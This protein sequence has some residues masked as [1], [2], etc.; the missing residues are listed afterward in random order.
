MNRWRPFHG[1]FFLV[2]FCGVLAVTPLPA[3]TEVDF[4]PNIEFSKYKTFV[5][6]G[7]VENL[8]ML[9]LDPDVMNDR[10]HHDISQELA[11]K[12]IHEAQ[13]G[14]RA[15]LV[16]RYWA[17]PSK[18]VNVTTMG[19]WAPFSPYIGSYWSSVYNDVSATSGKEDS[20]IIDLI[21]PRTKDLVWRLYLIRKMVNTD[22]D[23]KKTDDELSKGFERFPPSD[24]EKEAKKKERA[25]HPP[26]PE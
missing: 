2:A 22:K 18:Q 9:Q 12:G 24:V 10:L 3:K 5:F 4:N 11:K 1:A 21:D 7:G 8:V 26:K 25:A 17:N 14:Q 16:V 13:P 20:L 19:N 23:W 15:D 6:I